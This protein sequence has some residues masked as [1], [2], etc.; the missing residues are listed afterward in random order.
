MIK[1]LT[2]FFLLVFVG[3]GSRKAEVKKEENKIEIS[4]IEKST[5]VDT[6]NVEIKTDVESETI[7]VE[8]K[9]NLKPFTYNGKTYFNVVLSKQNKKQKTLY[10]KDVKVTQT[11]QK[12]SNIKVE[13]S[14]KEKQTEKESDLKYY[15]LIVFFILIIL[16]YI[17]NRKYKFDR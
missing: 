1:Y 2:I 3:C 10:K 13:Q 12:R 6:S 11:N 5:F 8:A 15:F 7:I 14:K 16:F 17:L 9:D 4:T